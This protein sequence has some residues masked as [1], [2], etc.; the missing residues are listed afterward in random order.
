MAVPFDD[1]D[2]PFDWAPSDGDWGFFKLDAKTKT[3]NGVNFTAGVSHNR[4]TGKIGGSLSS[5]YKWSEYGL[6]F[7]E[8]WN[9]D[10]VLNTE[11]T[12]ADQIAEGLELG[13]ATSFAPLTGKKNGS[14]KSSFANDMVALN[15][16]IDLDF[17]GPTIHPSA[18][19]GYEGWLA[20]IATSF[21]TSQTKLTRSNLGFGYL[22]GDFNFTTAI[23]PNYDEPEEGE[24]NDGTEFTGSIHHKVNE[25]LDAAVSLAWMS[26]SGASTFAVGTKYSFDED[27]S[28]SAKVNNSGHVG[29]GY[30]QK[31][32]DGIKLTVSCLIDAKNIN[33]GGHKLGLGLEL[34]G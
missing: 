11:V 22:G 7:T 13:F 28:L 26:G 32:R 1:I 31:L 4:E 30:T 6:T 14:I 24:E 16:D 21:D 23:N 17:A 9:T 29:I 33:S 3:E 25:N 20:G 18:V 5:K 27:N 10:N 34:E 12:I 15:C 2:I 19:F 8:K